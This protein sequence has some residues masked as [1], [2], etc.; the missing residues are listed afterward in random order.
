MQICKRSMNENR[1]SVVYMYARQTCAKSQ[2][3][4]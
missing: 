4:W 2:R 1:S 3:L